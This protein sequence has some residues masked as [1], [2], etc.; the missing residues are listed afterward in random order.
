MNNKPLHLNSIYI[1]EAP[2]KFANR[3]MTLSVA[4]FAISDTLGAVSIETI[5]ESGTDHVEHLNV[6]RSINFLD[7]FLESETGELKIEHI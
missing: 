4:R 7:L 3:G 2:F 1:F 6:D 5:D